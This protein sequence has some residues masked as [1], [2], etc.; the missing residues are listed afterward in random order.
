MSPRISC[1][2]A[3]YSQSDRQE[4]HLSINSLLGG[5][6]TPDQIVIVV[7]GPIPVDLRIL[8]DNWASDPLFTIVTLPVNLGLGLALREGLSRC[9]NEIVCRFDTD[10]INAYDRLA[11]TC[12]AFSSNARLDVFFSSIIEFSPKSP[13]LCSSRIKSVPVTDQQIKHS[14][15]FRNVVNHPTVAF[16]R[17]SVISSG[18][19]EHLP[20]FEDYYLWLKLRKVGLVFGATRLPLVF[21][22]RSSTISRRFGLGYFFAEVH[23][24]GNCLRDRLLPLWV[25]PIFIVRCFSRLLPFSLQRLQDYLP[26]RS[27]KF[28]CINPDSLPSF[29]RRGLGDY[30]F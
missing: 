3:A 27:G 6:R 24:L 20:Y 15:L 18:S 11:V 12:E 7:D 16:R 19:Y 17:S 25:L 14:L 5:S 26:W 13:V 10:D 2:G 28:S 30:N 1:L 4:L 8:L 21:M 22:R 29:D 9:N 23:F